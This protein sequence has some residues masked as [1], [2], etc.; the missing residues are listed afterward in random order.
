MKARRDANEPV[1]E[2][3]LKNVMVL[4]FSVDV[5]LA[6]LSEKYRPRFEYAAH[7]LTGFKY[8]YLFSGLL[9]A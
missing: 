7:P 5:G 1:V 8:L 2:E 3:E 9:P 4:S 6:T